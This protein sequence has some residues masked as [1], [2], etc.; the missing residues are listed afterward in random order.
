MPV[1]Q[2]QREYEQS[3]KAAAERRAGELNE[4]QRTLGGREKLT[5]VKGVSKDGAG[6][7]DEMPKAADF[8]GN[9]GGYASAMA[10][11]RKKKAELPQKAA[12]ANLRKKAE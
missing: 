12:V 10:A 6:Y 4:G 5:D 7:E 9:M 2:Q 1:D 11:Y 8:K 3:G